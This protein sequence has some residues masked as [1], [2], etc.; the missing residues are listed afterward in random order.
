M[1][2]QVLHI[3]E[4]LIRNQQCSVFPSMQARKDEHEDSIYQMIVVHSVLTVLVNRKTRHIRML[5]H[6]LSSPKALKVCILILIDISM[7]V[8]KGFPVAC[9]AHKVVKH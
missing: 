3:V 8:I 5:S 2:K 6:F 7:T 4:E 9:Y 1:T